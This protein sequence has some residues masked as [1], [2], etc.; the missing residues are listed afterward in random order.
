MDP[1]YISLYEPLLVNHEEEKKKKFNF[2]IK[3]FK[4]FK[5]FY[6]N[7]SKELKSQIGVHSYVTGI[8]VSFGLLILL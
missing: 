6:K 4:K 8:V 2:N 5:I 7:M 3:K 1:R